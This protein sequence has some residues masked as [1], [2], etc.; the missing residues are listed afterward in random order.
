MCVV[1]FLDREQGF[2]KCSKSLVNWV[3][4][5]HPC[6]IAWE[7]HGGPRFTSYIAYA[8]PHDNFVFFLKRTNHNH[9]YMMEHPLVHHH[10]SA[11]IWLN[12]HYLMMLSARVLMRKLIKIQCSMLVKNGMIGDL[13][14]RLLRMQ[15]CWRDMKHDTFFIHKSNAMLCMLLL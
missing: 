4:L 1:S 7:L 10:I 14:S 6:L 2:S 9:A 13:P 8:T 15:S 11:S 3:F 12:S 5:Q